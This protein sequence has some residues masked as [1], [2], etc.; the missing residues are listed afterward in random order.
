[1]FRIRLAGLL[2]LAGV[3]A[4]C[5]G[6]AAPAPSAAA[7]SAATSA[8]PAVSAA[9]SAAAST[10][11]AASAA[12]TGGA[13]ASAKPAAS[14]AA[15]PAAGPA[16]KVIIGVLGSSSDS[17]IFVAQDKGY[18]K[19]QGIELDTQRFQ[20]LVDM[21]GP[22]AAGQLD[23]AAGAPAAGLYNAVARDVPIKIVADKGG[24]PSPEWDFTGLVLRKDLMD[25]G[26]IKSEKDLKG[27]RLVTSGKGN[28]PE[29]ALATVLK[30]GGLTLKD[31]D[32][33]QMSFPDMVTAMAN[34][35]IDGGVV[36]EPFLTSI[37]SSGNGVVWKRNTDIFGHNQQ[38][39][40]IAYGQKFYSNQDLARRWM[41]AYLK[42]IRDYN[43]AFGPKKKGYD[44]VVN[45]LAK[46]TTVKDP[47]IIKK[48]TPAGLNPDGKL[49]MK[50]MQEDIDYYTEAGYLKDKVDLPK[51]ID[52]SFQEYAVQQ[53][54]P[55]QP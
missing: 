13:S 24:T 31:I 1:M 25:S 47:A 2:T 4:A 51:L 3:L 23:I 34:K 11:P 35:G 45:I 5:G 6:G 14:G 54:G 27:L 32:F 53:L 39:A 40:I 36:I 10:K 44:D 41:V 29:V 22:T 15:K 55:Y 19:E 17:G 30:K 52:T 38:I 28:S 8:K 16:A 33:E 48:M 43:D 42:G 20:T 21:V 37:S 12:T 18:F 46:N 26:K 7:P 49:D 9:A 50:S